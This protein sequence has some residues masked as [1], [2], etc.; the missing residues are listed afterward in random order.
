[1]EPEPD[2]YLL[3]ANSSFSLV[4]DPGILIGISIFFLLLFCSALISGAE[5]AFFSLNLDDIERFKE[6][7][8]VT[9]KRILYL[10]D[11]PET[12]LATILISN[13]FV[14]ITI[15]LVAELIMSVLLPIQLCQSWA[16]NF[17]EF[18]HWNT[19]PE[20]LGITIHFL[21]TVIGV[22]CLLLLMGEI[23]PKIY[24][25]LNTKSMVNKMASPLYYLSGFFSPVTRLMVRG[26]NFLESRLAILNQDNGHSSVELQEAIDLAVTEDSPNSRSEVDILKRII[27]F[28]DVN[29]KQIMHP[30]TEIVAIEKASTFSDMMKVVRSSG[31]S[32]IPV[33]EEDLDHIIG[34]ILAKD[35]IAH[36]NEPDA[37]PWLDL[38]RKEVLYVPESKRINDLLKDFQKE[39]QHMAI[40]V[41][42]YGGTA[43]LITLEDIMEEIV[44]EIKDEFDDEI[45]VHYQKIDDRNY[46]FEGKTQI[47]DVCRILNIDTGVF[48]EV[49]GDADSLAGLMLELVGM[50]PRKDTNAEYRGYIFKVT[51]VNNRRIEEIKL[52]IPLQA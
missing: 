21:I 37:F 48:D 14:N 5:V 18:I 6:T 23:M 27:Q 41:D 15:I 11:K 29:V 30:R 24:A 17:T 36:V 20:R 1:M 22:T 45:E 42:E 7:R 25:R 31:Y 47:Q 50:I 8:S 51:K 46:L 49:R 40:A 39:R 43:G 52:T 12:L 34:I 13:N 4:T 26:T 28:A 19:D 35:L 32:R 16:M 3:L 9:N 2:S 44:G 10:L 33:Y 38:V